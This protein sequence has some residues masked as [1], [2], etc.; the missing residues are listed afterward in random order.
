MYRLLWVKTTTGK[1]SGSGHGV[2]VDAK[3]AIYIGGSGSVPRGSIGSLT[4]VEVLRDRFDPLASVDTAAHELGH[5]FGL[6]GDG[7]GNQGIMNGQSFEFI[8]AHINMLRWR[9]KS[10]GEQ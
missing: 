4:F 3:D 5:Q 9:V 2:G 7:A 8:P 6:M 1:F 10:P